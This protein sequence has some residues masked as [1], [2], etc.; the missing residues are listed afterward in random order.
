MNVIER[1]RNLY[2]KM[3]SKAKIEGKG[4]GEVSRDITTGL[5]SFSSYRFFRQL[6]TNLMILTKRT[7]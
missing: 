3:A 4:E 6:I 5:D 2:F 7:N 1:T